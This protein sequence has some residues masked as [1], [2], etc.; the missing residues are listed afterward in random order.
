MSVKLLDEMRSHAGFG[1][2]Q[3]PTSLF[4]KWGFDVHSIAASYS[5]R[6]LT[7]LDV[8]RYQLAVIGFR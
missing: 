8:I 3:N 4:K 6:V 2:R 7:R 5:N 1:K